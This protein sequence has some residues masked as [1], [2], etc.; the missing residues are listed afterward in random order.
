VGMGGVSAMVQKETRGWS[1]LERVILPCEI[2]IVSDGGG[3]L[4]VHILQV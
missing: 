2:I 3:K 1:G 4:D